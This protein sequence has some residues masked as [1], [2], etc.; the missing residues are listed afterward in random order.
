MTVYSY[1]RSIQRVRREPDYKRIQEEDIESMLSAHY[2][3]LC[4]LGKIGGDGTHSR[5]SKV[6]EVRPV[7]QAAGV[8]TEADPVGEGWSGPI[9]D[10]Y[11][12]P[13]GRGD[14]GVR[15][16][17][18][19]ASRALASELGENRTCTHSVTVGRRRRCEIISGSCFE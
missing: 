3:I 11:L 19:G 16:R 6:R 17:G 2:E 12:V 5:D 14:V 13:T 8:A 4:G 7:A 1:S 10:E 9:E 18:D 15:R